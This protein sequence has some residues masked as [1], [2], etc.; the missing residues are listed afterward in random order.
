[1]NRLQKKEI[2]TLSR[3]LAAGN[4]FDFTRFSYILDRGVDIDEV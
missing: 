3:L 1:M 2:K 4:F